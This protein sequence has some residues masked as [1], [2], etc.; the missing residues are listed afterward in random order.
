MI[1]SSSTTSCNVFQ[2]NF[3]DQLTYLN[4]LHRNGWAYVVET[5]KADSNPNGITFDL[6]IESSFLVENSF[7][8]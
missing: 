4:G 5:L 3:E 8:D 2:R 7:Y 1:V 6:N